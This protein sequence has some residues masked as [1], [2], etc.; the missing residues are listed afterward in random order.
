MRYKKI[1]IIW[2]GHSGFLIK[3]NSGK[4]I[5]IDPFKISSE[6]PEADVIFTTHFHYDH[7]S[8]EDINKIVK[9]GTVIVCTPD[10][11]SK[12]SHL[13]K[14][15]QI[16]NVEPNSQR[17]IFD[18]EIKLWTIPAY[19]INKPH[20]GREEDWVG[21]LIQIDDVLIYHAGDTDF[22]PEMKKL[23]NI[24]VAM[25][26]VGGT[27]TMNAGEAA[28]AVALIKP[29]LAIPMH[30]NFR[31]SSGAQIGEKSDAE[32]FAKY[33]TA[34]GIEVKILEVGK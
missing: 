1:E 33:C 30:F 10:S 14:K 8:V 28:K 21:Y 12:M 27:F 7:F 24:D 17:M 4:I 18:N 22:I 26:P 32:V 5:Y 29:K 15:V 23:S 11:Q 31:S 34:E 2:L 13:D 9:D 25:L 6:L 20:H 19:N 16:M 3:S